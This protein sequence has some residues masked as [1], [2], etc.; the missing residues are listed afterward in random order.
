MFDYARISTMTRYVD[1][2]LWP[3]KKTE[4]AQESESKKR[5][6]LKS[7][8]KLKA[9]QVL[10]VSSK[11]YYYTAN[12]FRAGTRGWEY[13]WVLEQLKDLTKGSTVLDCGCGSSDFMLQYHQMGLK[14]IGLDYV[15]S[16]KHPNSELTQDHVNG[17]KGI[18]EF[19]SGGMQEIPLPD[20]TI[21]AITSISV[22]E[23]IVIEHKDDPEYHKRCLSEA[24]RVLKP[25][26]VLICT[27]D[28][29][30]KA[31][32][33]YGGTEE[34]GS[35]GWSYEKDIEYLGMTLKDPTAR[36]KSVQEID[37]DEDAFFVPPDLYLER[38]YG[39][40]F[41]LY[42]PYHRLTSVGFALVKDS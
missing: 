17:R 9:K 30:L 34:W 20:N 27:Y 41:N 40:G 19:I 22:V 7:A 29:P 39:S 1:S 35:E 11:A 24:K 4:L 13:P 42:G 37:D 21:D 26:G 38:G 33:R 8:I 6:S 3:L 28:T 16:R 32:V 36:I 5:Q 10:G 31:E 2:N 12:I 15:R 18:V 25:G 23:H 14:P